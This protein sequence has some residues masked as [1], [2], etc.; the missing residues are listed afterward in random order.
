MNN[1]PFFSKNTH[2]LLICFCVLISPFFSVAQKT[3]LANKGAKEPYNVLLI[4]VDDLRPELG[5][6]GQT[7]I[8][9]PNID[10]LAKQGRQFNRAYCQWAVCNPSRSSMLTGLRPDTTRVY[11]NVHHFRKQLPHIKTLPQ[12]FKEQGYTTISIGK[13]FHNNRMNDS[14]S[15]SKYFLQNIEGTH[16]RGY[17]SPEVI[18]QSNQIKGAWGPATERANM[19]DSLYKDVGYTKQAIQALNQYKDSL[20]FMSVGFEKPH[21]PFAAP[22]KYWDLYPDSV[23]TLPTNRAKPIDSYS[24]ALRRLGEI[25]KYTDIGKRISDKQGLTLIHGYYACVSFIDD[26]IGKVLRELKRLGLA[27]NTIVVLCGDHG[28][29]LG[30]YGKWGKFSN[31]EI[32]TRTPLIIKVPNMPKAGI[33]TNRIVELLDIFPTLCDINGLSLPANSLQGRNFTKLLNDP[34]AKW[35][36][37][38]FSQQIRN[39]FIMG[40]SLRTDRFRFTIWRDNRTNKIVGTELYDHKGEFKEN[41]NMIGFKKYHRF[42]RKLEKELTQAVSSW[43][44]DTVSVKY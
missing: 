9:S 42:Q 36:G 22:Q 43:A 20:F 37:R 1:M 35:N 21:L 2:L 10:R 38:A 12:H 6:Y 8:I 14:I 29:K 30:D 5:C 13:I 34:N 11:R 17:A 39:N 31:F 16:A 32:D 27:E 26:Q 25:G 7:K 24:K 33:A 23:I 44:I 4:M 19:P 3:T 28:W 18:Q 40:Y 41:K 15:W